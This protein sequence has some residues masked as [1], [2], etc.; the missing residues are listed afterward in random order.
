MNPAPSFSAIVEWNSARLVIIFEN[1]GIVL[2]F[3]D[4]RKLQPVTL[5]LNCSP[6]FSA[7]ISAANIRLSASDMAGWLRAAD[8]IDDRPGVFRQS[9]TPIP[10]HQINCR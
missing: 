8:A 1:G 2:H 4:Y 7:G 9:K 3:K 5:E 10:K 6:H